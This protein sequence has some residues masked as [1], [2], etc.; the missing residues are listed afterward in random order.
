MAWKN[1]FGVELE[2][3]KV[4][5]KGS[6]EFIELRNSKGREVYSLL[7]AAKAAERQF[8]ENWAAV[9]NGE[10]GSTREDYLSCESML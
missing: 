7:F 1:E 2:P 4:Q 6:T 5:L 10:E 8:G 9:Y 3:F